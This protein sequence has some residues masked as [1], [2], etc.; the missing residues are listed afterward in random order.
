MDISIWS[1][2]KLW[3]PRLIT[4]IIVTGGT[5]SWWES[6]SWV[7]FLLIV[8]VLVLQSRLDSWKEEA[9]CTKAIA[10]HAKDSS[11]RA[12]KDLKTAEQA[13]R[14]AERELDDARRH[15][16]EFARSALYVSSV[17]LITSEQHMTNSW[18]A[19]L[20]GELTEAALTAAISAN[21]S[22]DLFQNAVYAEAM[23]G[24]VCRI[25]RGDHPTIKPDELSEEW[26]EALGT[27]LLIA[28]MDRIRSM[29][30]GHQAF[31]EVLG[32]E[33]ARKLAQ[34]ML[35]SMRK[36]GQGM[37]SGRDI[38]ELRRIAGELVTLD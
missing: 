30:H 36:E 20:R 21:V 11:T 35:A 9:E 23:S 31:L 8:T 26:S 25:L 5:I 12:I 1:R 2:L 18:A 6:P 14:D 3:G 37:P 29:R 19:R 17:L 34:K 33:Q 24:Q 15:T 22:P 38:D 27:I 4:V 13:T 16:E 28:M 32:E 7:L 10:R